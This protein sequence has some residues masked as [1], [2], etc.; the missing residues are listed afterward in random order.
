MKYELGIVYLW[1]CWLDDCTK[2]ELVLT[3]IFVNS[4]GCS[5]CVEG[6]NTMNGACEDVSLT[7][8]GITSI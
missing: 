6:L 2:L 3:L 1:M 5:L 4:V 7:C 8:L